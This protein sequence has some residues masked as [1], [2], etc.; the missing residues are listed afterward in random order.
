MNKKIIWVVIVIVVILIV[1]WLAMRSQVSAP[2]PYSNT[3]TVPGND[4]VTSINQDL[5]GISS[6]DL[7]SE[8]QSIDGELNK[9]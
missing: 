5:Q 7:N 9:L 2:S 8:F 6:T 3:S 4:T 1:V